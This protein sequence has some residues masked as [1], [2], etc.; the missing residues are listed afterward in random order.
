MCYAA[1][2]AYTVGASTLITGVGEADYSGYPDCRDNTMKA[3]ESAIN[4]GMESNLKIETQ[5]MF[6]S[7]AKTF[8]LAYDLGGMVFVKLIVEKTHTCY[9]SLH[10]KLHPWGYGCGC[11]PSCRLRQK[12]YEEFLDLIKQIIKWLPFVATI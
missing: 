6:L 1:S 8:K 9:E 11:C 12:G 3:L 5:L 7:K 10:D 2:Y 4:L